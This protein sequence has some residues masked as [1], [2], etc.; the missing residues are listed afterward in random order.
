MNLH[1]CVGCEISMPFSW[2]LKNLPFCQTCFTYLKPHTEFNSEFYA[3]YPSHGVSHKI[4]RHWKKH[5]H[6]L[7]ETEIFRRA[8]PALEKLKSCHRKESWDYLIPI[9]QKSSRAFLLG[10]GP[11][12][13]I[14]ERL[15]RELNIPV[16]DALENRSSDGSSQA[17]KSL[18]ERFESP[19]EFGVTTHHGYEFFNKR[20][21]LVDDFMTS[22]QTLKQAKLALVRA[23]LD[24]VSIFVLGH[25]PHFFNRDV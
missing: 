5:P 13:R 9:P 3:V 16:A 7:F 2:N 10:G 6:S 25:R 20:A 21:L 11:A 12:R 22:G 14:A 23:G 24:D 18:Q 17:K 19:L 1:A 4:L 15:A 8:R